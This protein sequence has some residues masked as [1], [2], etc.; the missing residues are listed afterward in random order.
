MC[1]YYCS[2]RYENE[3]RKRMNEIIKVGNHN[4]VEIQWKGRKVITTAQ[5]AEVYETDANNVQAN[6]GRNQERFKEGVHYF[7]LK[8]QELREFKDYLTDSQLVAKNAPLLYLWTHRGASRHCKILDTEKAWE[9]F[10]N[11]E[12]A[13]FNPQSSIN[14]DDLDPDTQ[15]MNLLVRN[16]SKQE[17]EQKRQREEQK[18][19]AEKLEQ[20]DDRIDAIKEV[21][22]LRPNAW[23]KDTANIINKMALK[24]G[25]YDHIKLIRDESYR[26]LE[27]RMHVALNIRL[28]NKKKTM[29]LNNV[30]KSKLDKLNIL[31]VIA[32]DP[33]L[34]EGY[35]SVIKD[36]AI[37]YGI[38]DAKDI[39]NEN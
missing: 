25:G 30:C 28:T 39:L 3:G 18:R 31:D 2:T 22:S 6:F 5:L 24:A 15:L 16:I 34:I 27:E 35:I 21:V 29:A 38:A 37:K 33:K 1:I 20:L 32:D 11:L 7:L 23:R 8:G 13:Y 36:M 4:V 12:E 9:Q 14:M 17:L 19:Q 26:I 10:D